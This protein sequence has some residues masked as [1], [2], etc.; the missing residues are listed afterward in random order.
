MATFW[1]IVIDT[2]KIVLGAIVGGALTYVGVFYVYPLVAK[3]VDLDE[4]GPAREAAITVSDPLLYARE[5]LINDRREEYEYLSKLLVDSADP[6]KVQFAPQ[7]MRDMSAITALNLKASVQGGA[8]TEADKDKDKNK[9]GATAKSTPPK[10]SP[11]AAPQE[12]FRDRQAYRGDLRAALASVNLDDLHDLAGNA[13]FRLQ[14]KVATFPGQIKNKFGV[15][16]LTVHPPRLEDS[17]L[18]SLYRVWLG[19][20]SSRLNYF[21]ERGKLVGDTQYGGS[22]TSQYM[23]LIKLGL[24]KKSDPSVDKDPCL[25]ARPTKL[26]I[27]AQNNGF[28]G[29][30]FF[31]CHTLSLAVPPDTASLEWLYTDRDATLLGYFDAMPRINS[32]EDAAAFCRHPFWRDKFPA[33]LETAVDVLKT[34]PSLEAALDGVIAGSDQIDRRQV[35]SGG[36]AEELQGLRKDYHNLG[37]VAADARTYLARLA[38]AARALKKIAGVLPAESNACSRSI[39]IDANLGEFGPPAA[40][41]K[42]L[43]VDPSDE[44]PKPNPLPSGRLAQGQAYAYGTTPL[45]LA[46]RL[47][48][49]ASTAA[50]MEMALAVSGKL[51]AESGSLLGGSDYMRSMAQTAAFLERIPLVVGFSDRRAKSADQAN[52]PSPRQPAPSAPNRAPPPPVTQAPPNPLNQVPPRPAAAMMIP[53][54]GGPAPASQKSPSSELR[55]PQFGWVFGPRARF[56]MDKQRFVFEQSIGSFDVAADISVPSWWPKVEMDVETAWIGNWHEANEVLRKAERSPRRISVPLPVNRADLD[57]LTKFLMRDSIRRS[58]EL[59]TIHLVEPSVISACA[60]EVT[61]LIYGANVWRSAEVYLGGLRGTPIKVLPDMEGISATFNLSEFYKIHN[62]LSNPLGYEEVALRVNTRNGRDLRPIR[63][64]GSRQLATDKDKPT[65]CASPY[66]VSSPIV[67]HQQTSAPAIF[68]VAPS[69][70]ERCPGEV[71]IMLTGRNLLTKQELA[72][73]LARPQVFLNGR[74]GKVVPENEVPA[75]DKTQ[76]I[77][78]TFDHDAA[79]TQRTSHELIV[80]NQA[81]FTTASLDAMA[82]G[83]A[84]NEKNEKNETVASTSNNP[85]SPVNPPAPAP[86]PAAAPAPQGG[87]KK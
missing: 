84:K 38:T 57:G 20:T 66:S 3:A 11:S 28:V 63:I 25:S 33:L 34:E 42:A 74:V 49:T 7:V 73:G 64:V 9:E 59:T 81:G 56:D 69:A 15:A 31:D 50:S 44:I 51:Q 52:P 85:P 62:D 12:E 87:A 19:H 78:V 61:V 23:K 48:T 21:E 79:D 65:K 6:S 29:K 46:Q 30:E 67:R 26:R 82:C 41:V 71:R 75:A 10:G 72:S 14:F 47:S 43:T 70:L 36:E 27:A 1:N 24:P 8:T 16:Q 18:T 80:L 35:S 32:R 68:A 17:D 53:G 2:W 37:T 60:N 77:S 39:E 5:T 86:A 76:V 55:A 22:G 58:A 4:S 54:S 83:S 40:F 13:L 45:E